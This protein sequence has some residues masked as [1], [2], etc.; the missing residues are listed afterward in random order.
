MSSKMSSSGGTISAISKEAVTALQWVSHQNNSGVL[1]YNQGKFAE[2][3]V[4]FKKATTISKTFLNRRPFEEGGSKTNFKVFVTLQILPSHTTR[5]N[6][7]DF[8]M[9]PSVYSNPFAVVV[10]SVDMGKASFDP[11]MMQRQV[12]TDDVDRLLFSRLSTILIFN[13]ALC[14][15]ARA[16]SSAEDDATMRRNFHQKAQ[17]L[18]ILAYSIPKGE[19]EQEII[20]EV[21]MPLFVQAI[22]NN[23]GQCYASLDD[24]NNSAACFELL[25]RSIILFRSDRSGA[26]NLGEYGDNDTNSRHA[27]CFL[28]NV[29]FLILKNPG[30]A[31]A[32]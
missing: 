3:V 17:E 23:L 7:I 4:L 25:L 11:Q 24:T 30:F 5:S 9:D 10:T 13:L 21:L 32:A 29:L 31:P 28:G 14:N 20:D 18:Y 8:F 1:L 6:E 26:C 15:H 19:Q 12:L 2:A 22:F 16:H 27:P